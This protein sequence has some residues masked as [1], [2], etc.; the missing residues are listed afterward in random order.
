MGWLRAIKQRKNPQATELSQVKEELVSA[1]RDG[2]EWARFPSMIVVLGFRPGEC[3]G[4][5]QKFYQVSE[6]GGG[7][8]KE[9][10]L[11]SLSPKRLRG[12]S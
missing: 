2:T 7:N 5:F 10:G 4:I 11:A 6:D 9:R 8:P 3:Q 12:R 1:S